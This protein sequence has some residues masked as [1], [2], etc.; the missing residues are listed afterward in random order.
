VK[1]KKALP[2]FHHDSAVCGI[3]RLK[4]FFS[5]SI[6]KKITGFLAGNQS[7][8]HACKKSPFYL[9]RPDLAATH[10]AA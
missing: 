2:L 9:W 7:R 4:A 1:L 3:F 8:I 6:I 5:G 10:P